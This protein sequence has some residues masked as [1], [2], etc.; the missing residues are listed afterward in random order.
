MVRIKLELPIDSTFLSETIYEG[1]LFAIAKSNSVR[2][3]NTQ[4]IEF[5]DAFLSNSFKEAEDYANVK[6]TLTGNDNINTELFKKLGLTEVKSDKKI[7]Q[8]FERLH[9]NAEGLNSKSEIEIA[10]KLKGR[11]VLFDVE[12]KKEGLSLQLLKV[13]RYTGFTSIETTYTCQQLTSYFS[14]ELILISLLGVY[15]SHVHT[16]HMPTARGLQPAY[17]FLFFSP[18][19]TMN[20][21]SG[22]NTALVDRLISIKN[23]VKKVLRETLEY[24]S[25][26]EI[27]CL[28]LILD[29]EIHKQMENDNLDKLSLILFRVNPEGHTY[30]IYEVLPLILHR[31]TLFHSKVREFFGDN[32]ESFVKAVSTFLSDRRIRSV[33]AS[34]NKRTRMNE[35]DQILKAIQYLYRFVVIG[36]ASGLSNF[37]RS[38]AEA[39]EKCKDNKGLSPYLYLIRSFN[40]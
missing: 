33:L 2:N 1:L 27:L 24:S 13:D 3:F 16:L 12:D 37:I 19:E 36:D 15:S 9:E 38:V 21:F 28:Q 17:Y 30:K 31:Q 25:L 14:K 39:H 18:D 5:E 34:L 8:L 40:L 29:L 23:R 22:Y 20:L 32:S 26:N 4:Q 11:I 35:T 6:I 7:N 10:Y